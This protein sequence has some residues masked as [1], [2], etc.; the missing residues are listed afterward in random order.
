M[1]II[2][3]GPA[4]LGAYLE[5]TQTILLSTLERIPGKVHSQSVQLPKA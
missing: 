4:L 2:R 5:F 1:R 3:Q